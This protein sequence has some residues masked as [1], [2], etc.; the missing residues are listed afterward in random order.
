MWSSS[1]TFTAYLKEPEAMLGK[2]R[3]EIEKLPDHSYIVRSST[4]LEDSEKYT[5][6]GTIQ[7][8]Y[9]ISGEP[10]TY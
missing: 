9:P 7:G 3:S 1:S 8:H 2:L 4:T 6:C 10:I 5:Q